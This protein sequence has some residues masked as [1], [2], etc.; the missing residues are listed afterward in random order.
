MVKTLCFSVG[1][2]YAFLQ[3]QS[4][5][6]QAESGLSL[7]ETTWANSEAIFNYD[8]SFKHW[9]GFT[10]SEPLTED[11]SEHTEC[12]THG[13][14]VVDRKAESIFFVRE[15]VLEL[16]TKQKKRIDCFVWRQGLA[17]AYSKSSPRPFTSKLD[18]VKFNSAY[19]VPIIEITLDRFPCTLSKQ[20]IAEIHSTSTLLYEN[21]K[22]IR[23]P[24]GGTRVSAR[25]DNTH[26]QV[27]IMFDPVSSMPT[28]F[29][30][31]ELDPITNALIKPYSKSS[32]KFE[33]VKEIY[34]IASISY[35]RPEY[36]GQNIKT[37]S[38]GTCDFTWHQFNEESLQFPIDNPA[39]F[40]IEEAEKFLR[41]GLTEQTK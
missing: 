39:S 23:F 31:S 27:D 3:S 38:I 4:V 30:V 18:F 22:C 37:Q 11:F 29:V 36:L 15:L 19:Q 13:R 8:V 35:E 5:F 26:L 2:L 32:P 14:L 16:P 25:R 20:S 7:M 12:V 1:F 41:R 34:R 24:D 17:T 9:Q 33:K 6:S 10:P 28:S 21:S 40:D